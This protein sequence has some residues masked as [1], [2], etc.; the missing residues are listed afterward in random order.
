LKLSDAIRKGAMQR[1]QGHGSY[2]R[3]IEHDVVTEDGTLNGRPVRLTSCV[4]GAAFEGLTGSPSRDYMPEGILAFLGRQFEALK[5]PYISLEGLGC[6][7][8]CTEVKPSF[9]GLLVHLND[10]HHWT[11][12]AIADWVETHEE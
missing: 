5:D 10:H 3:L 12:E 11:R 7:E 8:G 1:P 2:F 4:L 9:A 6:P